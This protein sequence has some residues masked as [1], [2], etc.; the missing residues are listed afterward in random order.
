M[1]GDE[2]GVSENLLAGVLAQIDEGEVVELA[3]ALGNFDSP[4]GE[5]ARSPSTCTSGWLST[6]SSRD[7][8]RCSPTAPT[9]PL[10]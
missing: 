10:G 2:L 6:S 5:E 4:T 1:S 9:L 8:W 3:L 7:V